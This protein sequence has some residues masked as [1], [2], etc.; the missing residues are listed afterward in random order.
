LIALTFILILVSR[1]APTPFI[2][3]GYV[4]VF[5]GTVNDAGTCMGAGTGLSSSTITYDVSSAAGN[6]FEG[7]AYEPLGSMSDY[8]QHTYFELSTPYISVVST[9]PGEWYKD[10]KSTRLEDAFITYLA[11]DQVAVS[12]VP[13]IGSCVAVSGAG[14]PGVH[15]QVSFLTTSSAVTSTTNGLYVDKATTTSA[16]PASQLTPAGPI[17]TPAIIIETTAATQTPSTQPSGQVPDQASN[18]PLG[19]SANQP[20]AQ[21]PTQPSPSPSTAPPKVS[22][23]PGSP[24]QGE[25]DPPKSP[26]CSNA[27]LR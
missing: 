6:W 5:S 15:I 21:S 8:I 27:I 26:D 17:S 7:A 22:Q 19:Q 25:S 14:A 9:T 3:F 1:V 18:Q 13:R 12:A 24:S 4:F 11:K 20:S 23:E 10:A 16:V 2:G